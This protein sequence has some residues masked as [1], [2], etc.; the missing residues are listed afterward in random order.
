MPRCV[1]NPSQSVEWHQTGTLWT[2][3]RMS[4]SAAAFRIF[5]INSELTSIFASLMVLLGFFP[6]FIAT[7]GNQ[8]PICSVVHPQGTLTQDT[9]LLQLRQKS[10]VN[11]SNLTPS[12]KR[13]LYPVFCPQTIIVP[14]KV[15]FLKLLNLN[16]KL[17]THTDFPISLFFRTHKA[18][19]G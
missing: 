3:Y 1:A 17:L 6:A 16:S 15:T 19:T 10:A 2:L 5:F 8:T 7:T 9:E 11:A 18:P 4:Y 13:L 14:D 12:N